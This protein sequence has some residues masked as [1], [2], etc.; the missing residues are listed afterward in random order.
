MFLAGG[1]T[2]LLV[3]LYV[4]I[5]HFVKA[6]TVLTRRLYAF[7]T[8]HIMTMTVSENADFEPHHIQEGVLPSL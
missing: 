1:H 4:V 5:V 6:F 7:E 2:C 8:W 3:Y